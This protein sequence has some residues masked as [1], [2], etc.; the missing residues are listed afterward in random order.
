MENTGDFEKF[1]EEE[2]SID[3][4]KFI[5]KVISLLYRGEEEQTKTKTFKALQKDL[6]YDEITLLAIKGYESFLQQKE[7]EIFIENNT[8]EE[9]LNIVLEALEKA[10]RKSKKFENNNQ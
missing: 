6:T 2:K 8:R 1:L 7:L 10:L 4:K 5:Q 3:T 9:K